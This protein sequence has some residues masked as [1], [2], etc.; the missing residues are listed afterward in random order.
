MTAMRRL[1]GLA[2]LISALLTLGTACMSYTYSDALKNIPAVPTV[3]A[4]PPVSTHMR[5]PALL[6]EAAVEEIP[7]EEASLVGLTA[8]N[9]TFPYYHQINENTIQLQG[10]VEAVSALLAPLADDGLADVALWPEASIVVMTG[11]LQPILAAMQELEMNGVLFAGGYAILTDLPIA[12]ITPQG[13]I[14]EPLPGKPLQVVA[15][16]LEESSVLKALQDDPGF[17]EN[18]QVAVQE[19]HLPREQ[20][21]GAL[22]DSLEEMPTLLATSLFE[23][24]GLDWTEFSQSPYRVP[25]DWPMSDF[26]AEQG[27]IDSYRAT[28]FSEEAEEGNTWEGLVQGMELAERID[29]LYAKDL[30]P[31]ETWVVE[32]S[33]PGSLTKKSGVL[34]YFLIP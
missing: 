26:L 27:L 17:L 22:L 15:A 31:T 4:Q 32:Y 29:F 1:F 25:Y 5:T 2:L 6:Q 18:W 16:S 23:P 7:L 30:I 24:S 11:K 12:T 14:V 3:P 10:P 19:S 21:M 20:A 9:I 8:E 13:L 33:D 34:G 28:H